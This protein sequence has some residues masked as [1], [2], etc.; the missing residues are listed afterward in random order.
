VNTGEKKIGDG[1]IQKLRGQCRPYLIYFDHE[2]KHILMVL[3]E[4][5]AFIYIWR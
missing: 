5:L 1:M 4:Q 2:T 3:L